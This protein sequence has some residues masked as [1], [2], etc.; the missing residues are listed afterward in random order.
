VAPGSPTGPTAINPAGQAARSALLRRAATTIMAVQD[1]R[2]E[3]EGEG[4]AEDARAPGARHA[5]GHAVGS[6]IN[7]GSASAAGGSP[8]SQQP[9]PPAPP[10]PSKRFNFGD[11]AARVETMARALSNGEDSASASAAASGSSSISSALQVAAERAKRAKAYG[12]NSD[13]Q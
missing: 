7:Y 13:I 5:W 8:K 9:T 4:E 2:D 6:P 3:D 1:R 11:V 12:R 10:S